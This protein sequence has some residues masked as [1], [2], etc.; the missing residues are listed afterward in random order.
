MGMERGQIGIMILVFIV[1]M[2]LPLI[3]SGLF[4]IF[5]IL[6]KFY[7]I[8]II[9]FFVRGILGSGMLTYVISGVLIYIFVIKLFPIFAVG[10]MLYLIASLMLSGIIIFGLQ[11]HGF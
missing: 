10:Y 7:F 1:I 5:D 4:P 2:I 11:K 9:F 8:L 3:L 6:I